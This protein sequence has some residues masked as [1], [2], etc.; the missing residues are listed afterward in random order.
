[1]IEPIADTAWEGFKDIIDDILKLLGDFAEDAIACATEL[2]NLIE[3]VAEFA[4][5]SGMLSEW[6]KGVKNAFN[7]ISTRIDGL[8]AKLNG[9]TTF[10]S[11][12]FTGNWKKAWEG[13]K[14]IFLSIMLGMVNSVIEKINAVI[15]LINVVI[16]AANALTGS[17]IKTIQEL[18]ITPTMAET[19]YKGSMAGIPTNVF[20][21][22][23][24]DRF[25]TGGF[26]EDGLFFANSR[27]LV[28][29]FSN[30]R[31]AVANNA[32][33]EAGIEEAAYRGFLRAM[34]QSGGGDTVFMIDGREVFRAVKSENDAFSRRTGRSALA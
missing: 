7:D 4:E 9:I 15:R 34:S 5:T 6:C 12:V 19:E 11:G 14:Q 33:I 25:A 3:K 2:G 27:E 16:K 29:Q 20:R 8:K 23:D 26:P 32:Q 30:G 21:Y 31:T 10:L 18:S 1:M 24:L 17:N 22:M 13:L 28:G